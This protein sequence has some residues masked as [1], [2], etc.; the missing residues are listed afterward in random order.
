MGASHGPFLMFGNTNELAA[1]N[2][3]ITN[4]SGKR[5]QEANA[6]VSKTI[7][8]E[9]AQ[10]QARN[11][12]NLSIS[13]SLTSLLWPAPTFDIVTGEFQLEGLLL[14]GIPLDKAKRINTTIQSSLGEL[15]SLE[16]RHS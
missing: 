10:D 16:L 1:R 4:V 3:S 6:S 13:P 12:G 5:P 8:A 2:N 11:L 9:N 14:Y 15:R 7:S